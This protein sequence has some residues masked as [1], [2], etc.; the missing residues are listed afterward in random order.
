MKIKQAHIVD[1]LKHDGELYAEKP[2]YYRFKNISR[3]IGQNLVF[4]LTFRERNCI[5]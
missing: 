4:V 1:L 3:K 2:R 5:I